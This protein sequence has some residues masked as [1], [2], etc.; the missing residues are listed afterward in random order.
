MNFAPNNVS[1]RVVKI[2]SSVSPFGAVRALAAALAMAGHEVMLLEQI[3][4]GAKW[5]Y[6][7]GSTLVFAFA[8]HIAA[9]D[10][11][12]KMRSKRGSE[13]NRGRLLVTLGLPSRVST[14]RAQDRAVDDSGGVTAPAIDTRAS[15]FDASPAVIMTW[16]YGKEKFDPALGLSE[17]RV[18][19]NVDPQRGTDE[20]MGAGGAEK[21]IAKIAEKSIV[22][23]SATAGAPATAGAAATGSSE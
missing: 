22:N 12:F 15:T 11:Q 14:E 4:G 18:R 17:V 10:E 20:L 23:A 1:W 2:F 5:R 3:P 16:T 9:A 8:V 7:W 19:I 13:T 21:A 6:V